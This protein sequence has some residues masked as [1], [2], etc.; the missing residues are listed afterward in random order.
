MMLGDCP[1]GGKEGVKGHMD[2]SQLSEEALRMIARR[3]KALAEPM[4]LRL[5]IGLEA[6][7]KSVGE[8][9]ELLGAT[10]ANVSRHLRNLTEAGILK[11]RKV[12]IQVFYSIADPA[13]FKLCDLVCGSLREHLELQSSSFP[14]G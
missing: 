6:G 3:F 5:I 11:R 10:Q 14:S 13:V 4:R 8:L 1:L 9:V 7:E 12:G 2:R